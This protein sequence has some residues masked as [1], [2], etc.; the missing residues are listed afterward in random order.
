MRR[1]DLCRL[2]GFKTNTFRTWESRG[3]LPFVAEEFRQSHG[4]GDFTA[5]EAFLLTVAH[6]LGK[7]AV[8]QAQVSELVRQHASLIWEHAAS[9]G[10]AK[11]EDVFAGIGEF[12]ATDGNK[13][14]RLLVGPLAEMFGD[15]LSVTD[16]GGLPL[17]ENVFAHRRNPKLGSKPTRN[18][19][20]AL[21]LTNISAAFRDMRE[22]AK[23]EHIELPSDFLQRMGA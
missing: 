15:P 2:A 17:A 10:D 12:K 22:L 13:Y 23:R 11:S 8:G 18:A 9:I 3:F 16:A 4:W 14:R 1:D 7:A 21:T 5:A 19:L 6:S 20:T